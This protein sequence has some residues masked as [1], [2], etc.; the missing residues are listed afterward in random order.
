MGDRGGGTR[1]ALEALQAVGVVG[2]GLG[3]DL[4]GDLAAEACV[5]G[6]VNFPLPPAPRGETTS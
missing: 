1:L 3:E 5:P 6:T 2:Q 4:E